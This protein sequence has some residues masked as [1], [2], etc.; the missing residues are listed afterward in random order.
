MT[1]KY[2]LKQIRNIKGLT[3][4]QLAKAVGITERTINTYENNVKALQNA[5]YIVVYNIAKALDVKTTDIFLG[6]DSE[7]PKIGV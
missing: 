3:Q 1:E 2:T 4:R 7:K 6:T 5:D